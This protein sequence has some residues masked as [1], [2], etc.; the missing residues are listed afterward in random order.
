[1]GNQPD[2]DR[3]EDQGYAKILPHQAVYKQQ[4][5]EHRVSYQ[6]I[7]HISFPFILQYRSYLNQNH[8][9]KLESVQIRAP[10][11]L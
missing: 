4:R 11:F 3:E 8:A 2:D 10:T 6:G 7:P 1:M 5:V 9:I